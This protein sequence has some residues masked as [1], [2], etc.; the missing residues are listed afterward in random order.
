MNA[1]CTAVLALM[2]SATPAHALQL[3]DEPKGLA[4]SNSEV[5]QSGA[6]AARMVLDRAE[7]A[8]QS[9][10]RER[11]EMIERVWQQLGSVFHEQQADRAHTVALSLHVVQSA[12][13]DAFAVPD[14]TVVLSEAFVRDRGLDAAQLAFVLAHE[15]AHVLLEH[16]R[17]TLTAALALLP[18]NLP[19]SVDDVY[20]E[21]D[22]NLGLLKSLEPSMHQAE[23]E[24]DEVGLQLAALAGYA[25]AEQLRFMQNEAAHECEGAAVVATHPLARSRL[26]RLQL[27]LPLALRLYGYGLEQRFG[28]F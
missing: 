20:V 4:W 14:G 7:E 27:T 19:R 15:V 9:G 10:C 12:D 13:V 25:P 23:F 3:I 18:R 24:A 21:L 2:A 26:E 1:L 28:D 17:E 16:E 22:Y 11:C 6:P 5:A 8:G